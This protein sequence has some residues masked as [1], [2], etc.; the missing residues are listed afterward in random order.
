MRASGVNMTEDIP[1]RTVALARSERPAYGPLKNPQPAPELPA[2]YVRSIAAKAVRDLFL[3]WGLDA[4][5]A[6]SEQWNPLGALIRPGARVV[7]KPNWVLHYNQSGKG[8]DCLVTH[9]ELIEA[10]LE[11]VALTHPGEVVLGDAPLQGCDFH[12]LLEA[13]GIQ[14]LVERFRSRGLRIKVADFRRTLLPGGRL[15][16]ERLEDRKAAEDYVLVDLKENSLLEPLSAGGTEFRVTM[17]NPDLLARTHGPGRHRYLIAREILDCD[18]FVNLP[19]LKCHKK[20]CITGALKNL[21]GINGNKEFLPHHR[22]GGG[23]AGGDCYRGRSWFKERAENLLDAANRRPA[24]KGQAFL[25]RSAEYAA[26][27][28]AW[29]GLDD[30]LEGSWYGN[31]T[32][33]RT[34]L[35]LQRILRYAGAD[36][37]LRPDPVRTVISITDAIVGGEGEGPLAPLPV[38]SG[39]VTGALNAAAVEWVHARLMGIDPARVPLVRH[40]FDKFLYPLA[41]FDPDDIVVRWNGEDCPPSGL[42][43]FEGRAFLPPRGWRGHCELD[44]QH[45]S[46]IRE[47]SLVE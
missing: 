27:C 18:V 43:P 19:K 28:A 11:Y 6:N 31:D 1:A 12:A 42:K 32:I 45:D 3:N 33:W 17:Y 25:A 47:L 23:D 35:D 14:D 24:G 36:G 10:V 38:P 46:E 7:L 16:G 26:R 44:P 22:K 30:D 20:A 2:A 13:C 39:F 29:T 5:N 21:V 34:S 37:V 9:Q 40:A 4:G 8:L 15:G 41:G